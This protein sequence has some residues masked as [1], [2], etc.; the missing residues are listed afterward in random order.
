VYENEGVTLA[1]L[2]VMGFNPIDI[3]PRMFITT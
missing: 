3:K 2:Y 1:G